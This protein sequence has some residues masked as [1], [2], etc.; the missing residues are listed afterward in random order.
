MGLFNFN[1][2]ELLMLGFFLTAC[3]NFIEESHATS[4]INCI[5][6]LFILIELKFY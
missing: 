4:K 1:L 2:K 3:P 6:Q 5:V